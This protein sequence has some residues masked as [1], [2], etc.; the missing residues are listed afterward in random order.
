MLNEAVEIIR[1]IVES[2]PAE[3]WCKG[4]F[5]E[6]YYCC[7]HAEGGHDDDCPFIKAKEFLELY[8]KI[9]CP[10]IPKD[11]NPPPNRRLYE[12]DEG[13]EK[14]HKHICTY[15]GSS[16]HKRGLFAMAFSSFALRI[17]N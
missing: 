14:G 13:K 12:C 3:R 7:Q 11:P 6:W 5:E 15:C 8:Q 17:I 9:E 10:D 4:I 2:L 1:G 16:R